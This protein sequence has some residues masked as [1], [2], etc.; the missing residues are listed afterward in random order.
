MNSTLLYLSLLIPIFVIL[1]ILSSLLKG[2]LR[3]SSINNYAYQKKEYLLTKPEH[4]FFQTLETI[5]GN[6]YYIFPQIHLSSLLKHNLKGQ[7]WKGALS[8]IDRKSV[9]YVIC[10]KTYLSPLL[11][12][13]LDDKT[14]DRNDRR[15][16]DEAVE[17]ILQNS[18]LPLVRVPNTDI[19][20]IEEIKEKIYQVLQ[21]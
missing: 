3:R 4:E 13:E 12:I 7:N 1:A 11:I 5:I 17:Q 9:D 14:H 6:Q 19:N 21:P 15:D 16:R 2:K 8:H 18:H 10:D 20:K